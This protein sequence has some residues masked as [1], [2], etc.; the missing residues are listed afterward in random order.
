[1][2]SSSCFPDMPTASGQVP[3][4]LLESLLAACEI[5][6]VRE[7]VLHFL[8]PEDHFQSRTNGRQARLQTLLSQSTWV[9]GFFSWE[10]SS[11]S[12][13]PGSARPHYL[14]ECGVC[15][16]PEDDRHPSL[17]SP[18]VAVPLTSS[19]SPGWHP[20]GRRSPTAS[21]A[22]SASGYPPPHQVKCR[23]CWPTCSCP[24]LSHGGP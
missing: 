14:P 11:A 16:Y 10:R 8:A 22:T 24:F 9:L 18:W 12:L 20:L 2:P 13:V 7:D 6:D 23:P 15:S 17:P 21:P 4:P 1:M 3:E 19:W 5:P